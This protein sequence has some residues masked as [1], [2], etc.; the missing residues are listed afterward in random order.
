MEKRIAMRETMHCVVLPYPAQGH[1]NP[2]IQFSKRLQ[3]EGVR[4]TLVTTLFY[5]KNI[6]NNL[7][8]PHSISL[9]T[10]SD[11]FD[12]G[13]HGEALNL[14]VY[15]ERFGQVG[16]QNLGEL[17][18][19]LA[20]TG[21]PV[22]CIV[23]DSFLTWP[24]D[25]ARKFGVVGAVFLTQ[26]LPINAICYHV[27]IGKLR[28][29]HEVSLLPMLPQ[30]QY[31]EM[32]CF[33]FNHE[34]DPDFL[35]MLR[36]QFSNIDKADWVLCN[37]FYEL[38]KQVTDWTMKIWSNFRTI[39]PNIPSI[40]LDKRLKDD[41]DYNI[42][43]F[44]TEEC[45]TWLDNKPKYSV[46]YVSFGSLVSL[47]EEQMKEVAYSL[48][49]SQKYFLWV[50]RVSEEAKLPKD[51]AKNSEKGL[52]VT[53]CSQ[54]KVLAHEAIGCF[55]THCG[56]NSSIEALSLGVPVIV[57]PQWSDQGTNAKYLVDVWK[58]GIR[59]MVDDKKIMRKEALEYC[60]RE[61]ME[62]EKGKEIKI[63]AMQW[64]NLAI[65]AV[66]EG[67]SSNKNIIEF[68]NGLF[69]VQT[70]NHEPTISL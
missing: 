60:I 62:N 4:V 56:W 9:E 6:E 68:V 35:Q 57:L 70:K 19:N 61:L 47:D 21:Y 53:W 22:D 37:S 5:F 69:H 58:V 33:F 26:N 38:E 66:S 39:G 3:H 10:I 59:P 52:V 27:Y 64:K 13:R 1:M 28:H 51:F 23:Y 55:L 24:L 65:E 45:I 30:L 32:P 18:E 54:V 50:V 31:S 41:E 20:R 2:M 11:G 34:E 67:G 49:H 36:D 12:N 16:P 25:V 29:D 48:K 44:K 8:L 63:N 15:L 7:N 43:Q 40:F 14:R 46:V 17:L 42:T